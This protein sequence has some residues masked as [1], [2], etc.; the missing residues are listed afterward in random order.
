MLLD[1]Q[2]IM[3][4]HIDK[5]FFPFIIKYQE[6]IQMVDESVLN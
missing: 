5:F 1:I 6:N 2:K 4:K 3:E